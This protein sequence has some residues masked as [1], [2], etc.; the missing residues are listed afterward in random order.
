MSAF[1]LPEF[2]GEGIACLQGGEF[3]HAIHSMRHTVGETLWLTNG[4]GILAEGI[5]RSIHASYAEVE[6]IRKLV[7]PGEP[8]V[9]IG[10][11][12]PPLK[13]PSRTEWLVE[14]AVE[15]GA[16][17]IYFLPMERSIRKNMQLSRL[18]RVAI[19]ALKQNRRSVLP[20]LISTPSWEALPWDD[21]SLRIVGEIGSQIPLHQVLPSKPTPTLWIVG[22]EGDFTDRELQN[23]RDKECIGVSLG[24]LRLRAET[25]AILFLSVAKATWGY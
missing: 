8:P 18:E 4:K 11:V 17:A 3:V 7:R 12:V 25:A 13:Q 5:L 24:Q 6:V 20:A 14:K 21:F 22:P 23:L 2:S 10:L 19:A 1:Y 16:T 15:L 9:P